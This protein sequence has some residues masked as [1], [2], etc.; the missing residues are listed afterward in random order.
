MDK[1]R[2]KDMLT[3]LY[4]K[5]NPAHKIYVNDLVD[6]YHS[7]PY[8][9]IDAI[10]RKYNHKN[11]PNYDPAKSTD[12]YKIDLMKAYE[13]GG[14]PFLKVDLQMDSE[15]HAETP[16]EVNEVEKKRSEEL[17][18]ERMQEIVNGAIDAYQKKQEKS[19]EYT[20]T[21]D[22]VGEEI[23]LPDMQHLASLG[24]NTRLVVRTVSGKIAGFVVKDVTY[25]SFTL[26]D[27]VLV[28]IHLQKE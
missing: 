28:M 9:A 3:D 2:L 20:V 17:S 22:N 7:S 26:D 21:R 15:E 16:T 14:R 10:F 5:Y 1:E 8:A 12:E 27:K 25:D 24:I 23:I 4:E 13:A 6:K 18:E 19:I 11:L